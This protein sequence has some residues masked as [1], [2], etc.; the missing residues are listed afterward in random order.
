M[1][2]TKDFVKRKVKVGRKVQKANSTKIE[3]KAK[4]IILPSQSQPAITNSSTE[5]A[6]FQKIVSQLR[7]SSEPTRIEGLG[8]LEE[9]VRKG[10]EADKFISLAIPDIFELLLHNEP[11]IRTAATNVI[12]SLV[13]CKA[14]DSL[15]SSMQ[16]VVSFLCSGLSSVN[17]VSSF[18]V[19]L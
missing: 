15:L 10:K 4:K 12:D 8:E 5:Q 1:K 7:N 3:V 9:F 14:G 11:K 13:R 17:K 19:V 16:L 18:I 6:K 2:Q